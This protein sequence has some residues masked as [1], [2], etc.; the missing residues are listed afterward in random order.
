MKTTKVLYIGNNLFSKTGYPSMLETLSNL[1]KK[2]GYVVIKTSSKSN[3][4]LRM[5]DMVFSIFKHQ[6][7][8]DV[9]LIDTYSTLNFYYAYCCAILLKWFRKPYI[10]VL[11]GGNLPERLK[12]SPRM[13][14]AIFSNALVNVAPSEYLSEAFQNAGFKTLCIPNVLEIENYPF[15]VR[16]TIHPKLLYVRSF[17]KIYNPEMAIK[18]LFELKKD[19][20]NATLCMVGPDRD[21]T[22]EDV[23]ALAKKLNLENSVEFTGVLTKEAWHKKSEAFDVFINTS[24]V[25][26][27]PVSIIEAMALGLPVVTTNVG[28]IKF[29]VKDN[30][31]GFLV[32]SNDVGA[33]VNSIKDLIETGPR[34]VT[35]NARKQVEAYQWNVV[36]HQWKQ[37]LDKV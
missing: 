15:K 18:V 27:M 21:G 1:F 30:K 13:S 3:V 6:K 16:E 20:P 25:D 8:T 36:K 14:K 34:D 19:Y 24:N 29:L 33:M 23:K 28:G 7:T 10:P 5:L 22:L 32:N 31:T 11:H 17:A 26:N 4:V 37:L 2:E 12:K 35:K 9:A